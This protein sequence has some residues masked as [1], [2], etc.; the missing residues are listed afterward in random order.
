MVAGEVPDLPT[1][2]PLYVHND[3]ADG[4]GPIYTNGQQ[5]EDPPYET[6]G[7]QIEVHQVQYQHLHPDNPE[8]VVV[9]DEDT[10]INV[11]GELIF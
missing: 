10:D 1:E 9:E 8:V 11:D 5:V 6:D 3:A 4:R 2:A 7:E